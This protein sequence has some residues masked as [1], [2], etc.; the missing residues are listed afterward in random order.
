[1]AIFLDSTQLYRMLQRELPEGVYP[2]GAATG[3]YS[4]ASIYS[5]ASVMKEA[6]DNMELIYNNFFPL[7]AEEKQVDWEIKVFGTSLDG[8]LSLEDRRTKVATK[9]K[10]K[11]GI[12]I[13]DIKDIVLFVIGSDKLVEIAEWGCDSGSWEIGVSEL[14]VTTILSGSRTLEVTAFTF[15]G[16]DLCDLTAADVGLTEDQW[17]AIKTAAY[18]YSVLI[19]G[20]EITDEEAAELEELLTINEPARCAHVITDGLNPEEMIA[21]PYDGFIGL[22]TEDGDQ[23]TTEDGDPLGLG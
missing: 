23:L 5:K 14:G 6:Y 16:E 9:L 7:T 12:T 4:A 17:T 18:T 20:Y 3:S 15:P 1:M 19:Y 8:S 10:N 22:T 13:Q 11:P 21:G 2:D